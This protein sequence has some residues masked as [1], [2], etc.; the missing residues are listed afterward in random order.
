[1]N[2]I[3]E[4]KKI[5]TWLLILLFICFIYAINSDSQG[6]LIVSVLIL[7][8]YMA[9]E[10]IWV[11][12]NREYKTVY[13]IVSADMINIVSNISLVILMIKSRN[14]IDTDVQRIANLILLSD[15]FKISSCL[16]I[17]VRTILKTE[18]F[19]VDKDLSDK[20]LGTNSIDNNSLT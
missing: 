5:S 2:T 4:W 8:L 7:T 10:S 18:I 6:A 13:W 17:L 1:M 19:K 9:L 20:R 11:I 15:G 16:S 3:F 12:I 14:V